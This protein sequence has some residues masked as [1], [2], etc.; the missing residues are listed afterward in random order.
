MFQPLV[1]SVPSQEDQAGT[2]NDV[3]YYND[4]QSVQTGNY[5]L[6]EV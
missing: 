4:N 6:A 1:C 3:G 2:Q 5:R